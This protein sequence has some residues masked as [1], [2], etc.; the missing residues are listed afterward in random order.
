M[1]CFSFLVQPFADHPSSHTAFTFKCHR[2]TQGQQ[3]I[4]Y[5]VNALAIH[6]VY[7]TFVT[8]GAEG[9]VNSW[10]PVS[11]SR[12]TRYHQYPTSI[13]SLSFSADGSLLAVAVSY[14]FEQGEKHHPADQIMIRHV[15]P[16]EVQAKAKK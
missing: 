14:T 10:D 6:P 15:N 8:G 13:S 7:S 2:V 16:S 11:R 5:P 12:L 9:F 3:S 1:T 4:I